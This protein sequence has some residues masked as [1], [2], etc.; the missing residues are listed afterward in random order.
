MEHD[1]SLRS[2]EL[3]EALVE[4]V[5][6]SLGFD[7]RDGEVVFGAPAESMVETE[8]SEGDEEPGADDPPWVT[9]AALAEAVQER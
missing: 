6:G 5:G 3:R 9:G 8:Y 4:K 7:P 1:L 2:G